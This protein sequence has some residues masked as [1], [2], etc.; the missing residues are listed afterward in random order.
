MCAGEAEKTVAQANLSIT[1]MMI[2]CLV[3][4][5]ERCG[6]LCNYDLSYNE[7]NGEKM[8]FTLKTLEKY[9]FEINGT[10]QWTK[11]ETQ[12]VIDGTHEYYEYFDDIDED[13]F[14]EEE[15]ENDK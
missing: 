14:D 10:E 5:V 9:G 1:L 8:T 6:G 15:D 2:I 11:D 13:E 7:N 4:Y 3:R 12:K